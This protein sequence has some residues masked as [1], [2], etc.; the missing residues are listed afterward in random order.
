M[1]EWRS[2]IYTDHGTCLED[3][4]REKKVNLAVCESRLLGGGMSSRKLIISCSHAYG[5]P[6]VS[7]QTMLP[8]VE[9]L[10]RR[11]KL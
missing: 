8:T 1:E 3:S 2:K 11:M 5:E 7:L 4:E 10:Y 6:K 9:I